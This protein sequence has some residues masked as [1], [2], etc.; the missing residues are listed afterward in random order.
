MTKHTFFIRRQSKC[1]PFSFS[2]AYLRKREMQINFSSSRAREHKYGNVADR[3]GLPAFPK[4]AAANENR[5]EM[6]Y[7]I[8]PPYPCPTNGSSAAPYKAQQFPYL[9]PK[10]RRD[11][12]RRTHKIRSI[13]IR[14]KTNAGHSMNKDLR[15]PYRQGYGR[16]ASAKSD[17]FAPP[18]TEIVSKNG[19][20]EKSRW[21]QRRY[22][23]KVNDFGAIAL[24]QSQ[25]GRSVRVMP[26]PRKEKETNIRPPFFRSVTPSPLQGRESARRET[27]HRKYCPCRRRFPR[28]NRNYVFRE[29]S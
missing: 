10:R 2:M 14:I 5:R 3:C 18:K 23:R 8:G 28:R 7:R 9:S 24:P 16:F 27:V 21:K 1:P 19:M 6:T 20:T 11:T 17:E 22:Y 12:D 4:S 29:W 15:H 13:S 26:H 25:K